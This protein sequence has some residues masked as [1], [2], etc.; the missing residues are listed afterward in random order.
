[1]RDLMSEYEEI[2]NRL[3][4]LSG[5]GRLTEYVRQTLEEMSGKGL[6]GYERR[7][8]PVSGGRARFQCVCP[9]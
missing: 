3:A 1:M 4:A 5:G 9:V 8:V 7:A 6:L 2:K